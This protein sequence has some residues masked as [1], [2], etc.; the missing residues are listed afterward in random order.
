MAG[1]GFGVGGELTVMFRLGWAAE[2]FIFAQPE[3][4]SSGFWRIEKARLKSRALCA[5]TVWPLKL[6]ICLLFYV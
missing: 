3:G 6:D 2:G 1:L 5:N 4:G